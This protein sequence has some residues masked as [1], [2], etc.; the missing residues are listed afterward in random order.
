MKLNISKRSYR[1]ASQITTLRSLGQEHV[2]NKGEI[3]PELLDELGIRQK[4]DLLMDFV[5][6]SR[7]DNLYF[8]H[9]SRHKFFR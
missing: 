3:R 7:V 8:E 2:W 1:F 5:R 4:Q 9:I 6:I